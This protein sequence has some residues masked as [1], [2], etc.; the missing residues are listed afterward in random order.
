MYGTHYTTRRIGWKGKNPGAEN[1][2]IWHAGNPK[3]VHINIE[4]TLPFLAGKWYNK[5]SDF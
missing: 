1:G 4:E 2:I 3:I 5:K